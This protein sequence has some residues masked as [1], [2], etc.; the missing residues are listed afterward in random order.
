MKSKILGS[1]L[2]ALLAGCGPSFAPANAPARACPIVSASEADAA[3]AAGAARGTVRIARNGTTS[4]DVAAGV[5]HCATYGG[6]SV[7]PCRRPVDFVI[8]YEPEGGATFHVRVPAN[9]QYRFKVANA[10]NTCEIVNE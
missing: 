9:A 1:V 2:A 8:T 6:T 10:P 3:I 4:M 5:V 7:R